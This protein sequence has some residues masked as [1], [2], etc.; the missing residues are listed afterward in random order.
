MRFNDYATL[1]DM[2]KIKE[3]FAPKFIYADRRMDRIIK[4]QEEVN[5]CVR[6][7]D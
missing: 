1:K 2:K 6:T 7:L 4:T 3:E 5:V